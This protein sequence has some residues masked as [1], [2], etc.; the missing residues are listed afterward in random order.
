MKNI[1]CKH[2]VDRQFGRNTCTNHSTS[3]QP[4]KIRNKNKLKTENAIHILQT[5]KD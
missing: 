5:H 1:P 3:Q 2:D 4:E